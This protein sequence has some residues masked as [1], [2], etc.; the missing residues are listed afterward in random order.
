MTAPALTRPHSRRSPNS[1]RMAA[2]TTDRVVQLFDENGERKDKF[3]TKPAQPDGVKN[4]V[5]R[6]MAFSPDSAKL[7]IAQSDNIVFVYKLGLEWGDKKS[8]CN[9][10]LQSKPVTALT[11][12]QRRHNEVVF[13]TTEGKVKVGQLKTNKAATLY[14]HPDGAYCV[15]LASSPCGEKICSGHID[16]TVWTFDFADGVNRKLFAHS[17]APYALSWGARNAVVAAG[18]DRRVCFY[19]ALGDEYAAGRPQTFDYSDDDNARE[20]ASASFSP[21]GESVAVGSFDR[22]QLFAYSQQRGGWVEAGTK[23]VANLYTVSALGWKPDG[24]RLAT[25]ALCGT[26]DIYDACVK[27]QMYADKFEFTYVSGSAVVVKRLVDG[28]KVSVSAGNGQDLQGLNVYKERFLV[29]H[30]TD[31]LIVGDLEAEKIAEVPW[32]WTG[33]EKFDFDTERVCVVHSRGEVSVVEYGVNRVLGTCRTTHTK[34]HLLSVRVQESRRGRTRVGKKIAYLID[35]QTVRVTDLSAE[36]ELTGARDVATVSHESK[37]DW[38]EL[39]ARGT[40]VLF[41][42]K[43]RQLHLYDIKNQARYTLLN[44]CSYVQWVP[45]SDVVVAQNM[46]NLC[47]WYSVDSPDRVTTVPI[48][49]E[50]EDIERGKGKTEVIVEEGGV[51]KAYPLDEH[52]IEFNSLVEEGDYDAAVEVLEALPGGTPETEAM[53]LELRNAAITDRRL[54]VAQRCSA[55][56]GDVAK[57]Q[58]LGAIIADAKRASA[59]EGGGDG[60]NNYAVKAR[61]AMLDK[62]WKVA[63]GLLLENGQTD[64]AIQMYRDMHRLDRAVEVATS[65]AHPNAENLRREHLDWLKQTGQEEAAG[66]VKEREGDHLGAIRFYLRGGLPGRA[67][68]VVIANHARSTDFDRSLVEEIAAA[69]KRGDMYE[70]AGELYDAF[71][72]PEEAKEAFVRGHSYRRALELCRRGGSSAEEVRS[73]EEKWGDH[74]V[75]MKQQDAAINHFIEAGCGIKAIEAAVECKNWKKA[76]EIIE[77]EPKPGRDDDKFKGFYK[78]IGRHYEQARDYEQAER[79]FLR[80]GEPGEAVEMYCRAD[81]WE[82]AHKIAVGYMTDSDANELYVKRGKELEASA[83]Y[84]EAEKMYLTVKEHDLAIEMYKRNRQF[85]QMIRLVGL[86]RKDLLGETHIHLARQLEADGNYREAER[87]YLEEGKDWKG[88]VQMYKQAEMWEDAV[89]VAKQNGGANA[90]KRVAYEWGLH[91]GGDAGAS[92]LRKFNLLEEAIDY[93]CESGEFDNAFELARAGAGNKVRDVHLKHAMY[94]EDEGRFDEAEAEFIKADAPK[95]AIEMHVHNKDWDAATRVAEQH[96]PEQVTDVLVSRATSLKEEK[97]YSKAEATFVKAKKPEAAI[98][99]YSDEGLWDDALRVAADYLPGKVREIHLEMQSRAGDSSK[100]S[101]RDLG[102]AA[103]VRDSREA[104]GARGELLRRRGRLP[105]THVQGHQGPARAGK[106]V[107]RGGPRRRWERPRQGEDR[108]AGGRGQAPGDWPRRPSRGAPRK[109]RRRRSVGF[110][111]GARKPARTGSAQPKRD[112]VGFKDAKDRGENSMGNGGDASPAAAEEAARRGDWDVAHELARALGPDVAASYSIK[113][114]TMELR[115]GNPEAAADILA[116]R[117]APADPRYFA[118]YKEIAGEVLG[119][120]QDGV[121]EEGLK[122]FLTSLVDT[123]SAT[124]EINAEHLADLRRCLEAT[125]LALVRAKCK[126]AD[127]PVLSAKAATSLLRFCGL[128]PVDRA[129]FE[130][131]MA[132]RE[133]KELSLAFV[134]L[135]RYLDITEL[136]DE[137]GDA[138]ELDN[139]DFEDTDIPNDFPLPTQ[140]FV[141]EATREEVRD[142]VLALSMDQQVEQTLPTRTCGKCNGQTYVAG[143]TCCRCKAKSEACVVSGYPVP[144][145]QRVLHEGRSANRGD[146]N[147]WTMKFG[148]DPWSGKSAQPKY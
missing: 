64:A 60:L 14:A 83:R 114:A 79:C 145:G 31:S 108:G 74:L 84:K 95:E 99:M 7:A 126:D 97:E 19:D 117:G 82:N 138:S 27:R 20:F 66:A 86:Y 4:F 110:R 121:G 76:L 142:W 90:S 50:V 116:E 18:A 1:R 140:H 129:F 36:N 123:M 143:L 136:M 120:A 94:L 33:S 41:R 113:H 10:F 148:T 16:G 71:D 12:P 109:R 25:G 111:A 69:L 146:W 37:I 130:A 122:K 54:L 105:G 22:F 124:P 85:D 21:A 131:G 133:A 29:A 53:W 15:A 57:A 42:D 61:L 8:I 5:V 98:K 127:M 59:M 56:L 63:E 48:K 75:D 49:G 93:A 92:L 45:G 103:R 96:A 46:G 80:A 24:S 72:R 68:A 107:G 147:E 38:L 39:N 62:Q 32:G 67:A 52:L 118:L 104:P 28:S 9:K 77:R 55:A 135:N 139:V 112:I 141:E 81:K 91:L 73:L 101:A 128:V 115:G 134:F 87:R 34:Q 65:K 58:Y 70:R 89:R 47:V 44:Y 102:G 88:A 23:H 30:T 17:C 11:W 35:A 78:R 106:R 6:G 125:N 144:T 43:K 3:S 100:T 13:A 119:G 26:V 40:H 137:G 132:C 51:Q 2:V